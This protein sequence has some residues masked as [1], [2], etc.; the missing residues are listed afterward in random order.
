VQWSGRQF[1]QFSDQLLVFSGTRLGEPPDQLRRGQIVDGLNLYDGSLTGVY[2]NRSGQPLKPLL[3]CRTI[4]KQIPGV[5]K[6]HRTITLQRSP[7]L[8]ALAGPFGGQ[9]KGQQQPWCV[10]LRATYSH[11]MEMLCI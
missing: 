10:D 2:P 9:S 3:I 11:F 8:N 6:R 4:R 1:L 7:Y 5:A